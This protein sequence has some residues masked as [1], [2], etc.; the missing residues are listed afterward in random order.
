[1]FLLNWDQVGLSSSS[2]KFTSFLQFLGILVLGTPLASYCR[3]DVSLCFTPRG[4]LEKACRLGGKNH[5]SHAQGHVEKG[6]YAFFGWEAF[7]Y[8]RSP[9]LCGAASIP[10]GSSIN[11]LFKDRE[12]R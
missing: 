10:I 9:F 6:R 5:E 11:V 4:S 8:L 2:R 1:M 7:A 3:T 12:E